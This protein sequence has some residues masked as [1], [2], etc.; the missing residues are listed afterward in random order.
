MGDFYSEDNA[1]EQH[2]E[3]VEQKPMK[4]RPSTND[5]ETM[6]PPSAKKMKM[7]SPFGYVDCTE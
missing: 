2:L 4:K 3:S 1:L 5:V 7:A 6:D